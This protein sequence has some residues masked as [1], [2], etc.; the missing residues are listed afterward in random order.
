[1]RRSPLHSGQMPLNQFARDYANNETLRTWYLHDWSL[2]RNCP[3]I[4][5]PPPYDEFNMPKYFAGKAEG[6]G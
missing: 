1:M 6:S 4:F 3:D 5:G 2:N